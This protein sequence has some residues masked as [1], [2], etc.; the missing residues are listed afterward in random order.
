MASILKINRRQFLLAGAAGGAGLAL[1]F[2]VG[3][4]F[5]RRGR[6]GSLP[7]R[8]RDFAPNAFLAI[9]GDGTVTV[10]VTRSEMGQGV[11]TAL[12]MLVAEEL[13]A[14]WSRIAVEQAPLDRSSYG[15]Q[16]TVAS[17]SIR[18]LWLPL[19]RA[20]ATAREMLITAAAKSMAVPRGECRAQGGYIIHE[21][22][23]A[24]MGFGPLAEL[25][26]ALPVPK[27][28]D[29]Q[30]KSAKDFTVLGQPLPR[31]D[32]P[33]KV[34]GAAQYGLDVRRPGQIY[35]A[36]ARSPLIGGRA[37]GFDAAPI[38]AMAGVRDVVEI[39]SGI[40][41]VAD[42]TWTALRGRDALAQA[43]EWKS[44]S[45]FSTA[46]MAERLRVV[47]KGDADGDGE[48]EEVQK[49]GDAAAAVAATAE[50]QRVEA[51]YEVPYLAHAAMEPINCTAH[52][53]DGI[54]HIWVPT[55]DP[56]RA[57][58]EVSEHTGIPRPK[59]EIHTTLLG[60]GFGRR[61]VPAEVLEAAELAQ[62][63]GRPTQ[64]VWSREDDIRHDYYRQAT[65]HH[66]SA[67]L[68]KDGR[69]VAWRQRVAGSLRRAVDGV[70][71][72][73]YSLDNLSVTYA[74]VK[75][76]L[77]LGIWRAVSH[78]FTAFVV[79]SFIDEL[80][81]AGK[82]DPVALRDSLLAKAPRDKAVLQ[83]VAEMADWGSEPPPGRARGVAMHPC[84]GSSMAQIA[85]VS[86]A[87]SGKIHVHRLWAAIDCGQVVNPDIVA[88]QIE[89][90]VAYGLS[91]ALYGA[92]NVDKQR[93]VEGNF[94]D[95]R[96][97]RFDEMPEVMVRIMPSEAKP[98]G[99]GEVGLPPV[100]PAVANAVYAATKQRLRS[101]PLK[102]AN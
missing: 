7:N 2:F 74:Q 69:P 48:G 89:S 10:W 3:R 87:D 63:T 22:S 79:E 67:A 6:G 47:A 86:V 77:P 34:N 16:A 9:D 43:V 92:I 98:G 96:V 62:K 1:G 19:R 76:A 36:V 64:V 49:I 78:S 72:M 57:Q 12:P 85:E 20:G 26:R 18:Q 29:V 83:A 55:Q 33:D 15:S 51:L 91:A 30:L 50:G 11:R 54:C 32:I 100:A 25:A 101:L 28:K 41:V 14:D 80:A 66:V 95:Y 58:I 23:G 5:E 94:H 82:K 8:D 68:G 93:V 39:A 40:A 38:K 42:D 37:S 13:G 52:M 75:S 17:R 73:P 46:A 31:L 27:E 102:L 45:D 90:S 71:D 88:A 21:P 53:I 56:L 60:G 61:S 84:F 4:Q 35:A 99:V 24:K 97:L 44:D 59:I 70:R 81:V 65:A